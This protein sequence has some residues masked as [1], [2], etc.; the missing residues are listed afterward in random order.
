M[1]PIKPLLLIFL[2]FLT[3]CAE[4]SPRGLIA[5]SRLDPLQ[6]KPSDISVAISV[7]AGTLLK[8]GD[9]MLNFEYIPEDENL[10][11]IRENVALTIRTEGQLPKTPEISEEIYVFEITAANGAQLS[12]AQ[13]QISNLK[14]SGKDGQGSLSVT[15]TPTCI[16][17]GV[18][19]ELIASAWLRTSPDGAFIP[20]FRSVNL[21]GKL[22]EEARTTLKSTPSSCSK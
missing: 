3:A 18:E 17:H 9:A 10:S 22:T 4:V 11:A 19:H 13:T 5:A 14:K 12:T 15:V 21:W 8:N 7:P 2:G 16:A 20:L 6:T 1:Y